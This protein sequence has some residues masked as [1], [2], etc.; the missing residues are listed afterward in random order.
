MK[1]VLNKLQSTLGYSMNHISAGTDSNSIEPEIGQMPIEGSH[2]SKGELIAK[3][4][5][6]AVTASIIIQ[7]GKGVMSAL[8]RHPLVMFGLGIAAGYL[9]HKCRKQIISITSKTAE[10]SKNFVLRQKENLK[11]LLAETQ[12]DSEEK[13][14]SK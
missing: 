14:V 3:G 8:A 2:S 4:V 9:T 13:D 6:T 5:A 1:I 10:Q 11:D 12:E 7:S